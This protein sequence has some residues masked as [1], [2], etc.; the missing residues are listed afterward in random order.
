MTTGPLRRTG[1]R[2]RIAALRRAT[3]WSQRSLLRCPRTD[4][5]TQRS[6]AAVGGATGTG[7]CGSLRYR[8]LPSIRRLANSFFAR[9]RPDWRHHPDRWKTIVAGQRSQK[10]I[11]RA[12]GPSLNIAGELA[13]PT[14]ELRDANGA[15]VRADDNW[16]TGG[17]ET[18]IIQTG[19]APA[20]DLESALIETLA[21][22]GAYTAIVRGVNNSN[23]HRRRRSLRAAIILFWVG[24]AAEKGGED[25][26]AVPE[27]L[28]AEVLSL[29]ACWLSSWLAMGKAMTGGVVAVLEEIPS[30]RLPPAV[31]RRTG[32]W[33]V[34]VIDGGELAREGEIEWGAGRRDSRNP[35]RLLRSLRLR[36]APRRRAFGERLCTLARRC[37]APT[38]GLIESG[39]SSGTRRKSIE[40]RASVG[41]VFR[42]LSA[43]VAGL[44]AAQIQA[45]QHQ[46]LVKR[47]P[48]SFCGTDL[49]FAEHCRFRHP[50]F[51]SAPP[52]Q[53][54]SA[55]GHRRRSS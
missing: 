55:R 22:N 20:N 17:Q 40:A 11:V 3:I 9:S 21:G 31:G 7:V 50:G 24:Q 53:R 14:L 51:F 28:E 33:P 13:D 1:R 54:H 18:E 23:R 26:E 48:F 16:R 12:I 35:I 2:S 29:A 10:V 25:F 32:S 4:R 52:F 27:I 30:G 6:C 46:Q 39:V 43:D 44:D 38:S 5:P 41:I 49:E 47:F 19:I 34:A 8:S 45:G 36:V 42:G 15:L 37:A